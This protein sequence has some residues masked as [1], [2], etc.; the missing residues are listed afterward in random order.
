MNHNPLHYP[1]LDRCKKLTDLGFPDTENGYFKEKDDT[2]FI[3]TK[4]YWETNN[5]LYDRYV[6]PSVMEMID[7]LQSNWFEYVIE[8][9]AISPIWHEYAITLY[10]EASPK[11]KRYP[12]KTSDTIP[13]WLADIVIW[14]VENGHLSFKK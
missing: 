7:V 3:F 13:N 4:N 10:M 8:N 12:L 2:E 5:P 14:L 1:T 9:K 11:N 6:C